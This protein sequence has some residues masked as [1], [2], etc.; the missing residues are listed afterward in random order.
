MRG[1]VSTFVVGLLLGAILVL[2]AYR[3]QPQALFWAA[4]PK[5]DVELS[6][7]QVDNLVLYAELKDGQLVGSYFNQNKDVTVTEIVVEAVP[8]NEKNAFNQFT[9]HF[10]SVRAF[11]RPRSMS[12]F[13]SVETGALNP[14]FHTLRVVEGRGKVGQ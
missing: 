3:F 1:R 9:P 11:G 12:A 2:G 13:F 4:G 6:A 8:K 5:A 10:F 7:S 14:S